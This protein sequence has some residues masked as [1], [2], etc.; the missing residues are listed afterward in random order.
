MRRVLIALITAVSVLTL[1]ASSVPIRAAHGMVASQNEI[2]ST[3]GANAIK[4]GGTAV[5]A[6]VATAFALAVVH[7]TAGNIGGGGFMVYRPSAGSAVAYD[8]RETA[9]AKASATMF[10]KDGQY[11]AEL[12]HNS[13]LAVGVPGTVA[14]L[15]LAWKEQGKLPWR[16]LVEPAIAL[17]RDGF[18]VSEGLARSL[19]SQIPVFAK[20]PASLAQFTKQGTPY[21]AG[22]VLKQPDLART[23]E[24]IA[25]QG[26]AGFYEGETALAIEREMQAHGGLITR[27]DLKAYQAV[28]RTPITG[29]YRGYEII[30]MPPISSG[31]VALVEMLNVLEGYDL[32][33][34]GF[35]SADAIH[36]E[37]EAMKRAYADRAHFLGDPAFVHDMPL[38]RLTSKEYAADLRRTI[39]LDHTAKASPTTFDWPH[40][41]DETTQISIV[42]GSRNA[43]SLTY[44]LEQGYGV[45]I[46]V[47]GAGFLLNNEMGDFNAAPGLTTAEGLIGTDPNLAA[48]GKRML[49]SMTPTILARDGRLF[50]VTGSPGG[51]TIINTVL[52]TIL[53]VVD[54]GMNAQ[55]AVDAARIHDQWLPDR[56]SFERNGLS[57]DTIAELERRG[58]VLQ[59]GGAQGVAQVIVNDVREGMLEGGTDRRASDG[60]A[61]GVR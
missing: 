52:E 40:E 61:V 53:D 11:S 38:A 47:P 56:I 9:P 22:D 20:H 50:M 51:R 55:E 25:A 33:K 7:P 21:D 15:H 46:V 19:K 43:V 1:E 4:D 54:F 27:D 18:P 16:R 29:T 28:R 6:A 8:F 17:A 26:P 12:Q 58:H 59:A 44:T 24:R 13:Y 30:S 14:G 34:M 57:P 60:A 23:L 10:L 32:G 3:I 39:A 5:D 41:S 31:G 48:P 36:L 2:A 35:G 37:V 42:D 49:S 45:K